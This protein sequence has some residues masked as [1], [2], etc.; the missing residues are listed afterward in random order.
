MRGIGKGAQ[1]ARHRIDPFSDL[2]DNVRENAKDAAATDVPAAPAGNQVNYLIMLIV[3]NY[4]Q[5]GIP[6]GIQL[7]PIFISVTSQAFLIFSPGICSCFQRANCR[8]DY[9]FA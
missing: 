2:L 8:I 1:F 6:L 4:F 9:D 7:V 3:I 5:L